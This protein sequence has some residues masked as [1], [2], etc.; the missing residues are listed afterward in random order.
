MSSVAQTSGVRRARSYA[1]VERLQQ[2]SQ[3]YPTG[4]SA[5]LNSIHDA[6]YYGGI[7]SNG[8]NFSQETDCDIYHVCDGQA[9]WQQAQDETKTLDYLRVRSGNGLKENPMLTRIHRSL[10]KTILVYC[11]FCKLTHD[12]IFNQS[13]HLCSSFCTI[14]NAEKTNFGC[15]IALNST[16]VNALLDRF[17]ISPQYLCLLLGEPDY[18]APGDFATFDPKGDLIRTGL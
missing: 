12:H 17:Q 4:C 14:A 1:P 3:D 5:F 6:R 16:V 18:W 11:G 9:E 7:L 13:D 10:D 8:A 15:R 2:A